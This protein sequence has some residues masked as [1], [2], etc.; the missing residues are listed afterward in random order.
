MEIG[1]SDAVTRA[2]PAAIRIVNEII[3]MPAT[4]KTPD[5]YN[6]LHLNNSTRSSLDSAEIPLYCTLARQEECLAD[7]R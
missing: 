6:H 3:E 2:I 1:L 4:S 7:C 5:P